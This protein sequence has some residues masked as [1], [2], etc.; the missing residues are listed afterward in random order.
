MIVKESDLTLKIQ[1]A[2]LYKM[3]YQDGTD[4]T[5]SAPHL[6]EHKAQI[7]HIFRK[8]DGHMEDS[9]ENRKI[10]TDLAADPSKRK[11]RD[12]YGNF[13]NSET[14]PDGTQVWV[15]YRDGII[16]NGGVNK[17]ARK[18]SDDNGLND[19]NPFRRR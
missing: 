6:P 14:M 10:L 17:K 12:K 1:S 9:P 19:F 4:E 2:M 16:I 5:N 3:D 13:W 11:G 15:E 7:N 18:W 8:D